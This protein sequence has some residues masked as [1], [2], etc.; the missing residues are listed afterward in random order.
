M[1]QSRRQFLSSSAAAAASCGLT[2]LELLA[3]PLRPNDELVDTHVYL[4]HWPHAHVGSE[5]PAKLVASLRQSGVTRAWCGNFDGLFHKDVAA[6]NQRLADA[7][8]ASNGFLIPFGTINP[9]LP[10][11]EDDV[12]RCDEIHHMPGVRLHPNY[13]GYTLDNPLFAELLKLA[14]EQHLI[15]QL[16]V[17]LDQSRHRLLSPSAAEVDLASLP[18]LAANFP[19]PPIVLANPNESGPGRLMHELTA[20]K[21]LSFD[22]GLSANASEI[23]MKVKTLSPQCVVFGS[24]VPLG[25]C[26]KSRKLLSEAKLAPEDAKAVAARNA[27]MLLSHGQAKKSN[28]D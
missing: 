17:R 22:V 19:M 1:R 3:A 5:D 9:T 4:G 11:W 12:R 15:V 26:A 18:K 20:I 21:S 16:V 28:R 7:C 10:D 8:A 13:H 14:V 24:G 6:A 27:E 23:R 25:D 2:Q